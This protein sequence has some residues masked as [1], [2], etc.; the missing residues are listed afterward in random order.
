MV[1]GVEG[2]DAPLFGGSGGELRVG[3][4]DRG[5][6]YWQSG[7]LEFAIDA[8]VVASESAGADDGD[9]KMGLRRQARG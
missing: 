4:D 1:G 9:A 8:E 3:L 7:V 2:G 6:G 5:Q